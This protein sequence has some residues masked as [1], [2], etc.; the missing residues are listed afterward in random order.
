MN[1][2]GEAARADPLLS[3]ETAISRLESRQ[4]GRLPWERRPRVNE[5]L[6]A[7]LPT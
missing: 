2:D 3:F 4:P 7:R 1:S 6:A 5:R